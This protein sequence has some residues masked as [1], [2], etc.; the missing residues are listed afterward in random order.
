MPTS[1]RLFAALGFAVMIFFASE[2]YKGY[3]P[4][5]V[6]V[7]ML[8]VVNVVVAFI[9]GWKFMG[10]RVGKGYWAAAGYGLSTMAISLL[11]ILLIWS[12]YEMLRR[13]LRK[14][15]DEPM[16][17]IKAAAELMSD[18]ALLMFTDP[19]VPIVIVVG[20][21]LAAMLAEWMYRHSTTHRAAV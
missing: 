21:I 17:A 19:Q 13:S 3:L 20:G 4:E 11:Y 9:C 8:S 5:G 16:E 10:H 12:I 1:S 6:Q 14:L 7:A 15:Y 2:I 18:Y